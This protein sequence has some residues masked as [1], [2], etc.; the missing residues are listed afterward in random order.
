[1]APGQVDGVRSSQCGAVSGAVCGVVEGDGRCEGRKRERARELTGEM[2]KRSGVNKQSEVSE[3][4]E[5][6][7]WFRRPGVEFALTFNMA[8]PASV[9]RIL[10]SFPRLLLCHSPS[11]IGLAP[12]VRPATG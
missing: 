11:P 4:S 12:E 10:L 7:R 2:N 5:R 6:I 3:Q 9:P 1:M 8:A